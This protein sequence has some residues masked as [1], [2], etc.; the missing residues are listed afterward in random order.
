MFIRGDSTVDSR[1]CQDAEEGV[2]G[3]KARI[4]LN[5]VPRNVSA[6]ERRT[7]E[8]SLGR[9]STEMEHDIVGERG[10]VLLSVMVYVW[11][12]EGWSY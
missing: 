7:L 9:W 8:D 4:S 3:K 2:A 11:V 10:M 1:S 6:A 5:P 12:R